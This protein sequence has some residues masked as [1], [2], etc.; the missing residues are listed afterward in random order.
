MT[1]RPKKP[2]GPG[3][4]ANWDRSQ[5]VR[6]EENAGRREWVLIDAAGPGAIVHVWGTWHG[7]KGGPFSNGTLRIYLDGAAEPIIAGPTTDIICG[8]ALIGPPFS[9]SVS[10]E[11][12]YERRGH[13]LY[14]PIPYAKHCKITYE[15]DKLTDIGGKE[16]DALYYQINYRTY[17]AGHPGRVLH[18]APS[19]TLL[20]PLVAQVGKRLVEPAVEAEIG[21]EVRCE[22]PLEPGEANEPG[23]HRPR[24]SVRLWK[25]KL[26]ADDLP[27]ALRSRLSSRST[28]DG[29]QTVWCPV[30]DFFGTGYRIS[31]FRTL[32]HAGRRRRHDAGL[33]WVMPFEKSCRAQHAQPWQQ[34]VDVEFRG[35][36]RPSDWTWD[37]RSLHFHATWRQYTKVDTGPDKDQTGQ[38]AFDVNYVEVEGQGKYVGDTLTLFNGA[39]AWWG[40]GDEKIYVDGEKY[41]SH[42]GTGTEDYY[43]YAWCR[44]EYF[45]AP[46]HAQ[47][48][49]D[50][51]LAG[52][53]SV[54]SRY[55]GS[56]C[57]PLR[58]L[59]QVRHGAL[60][61]AQQRA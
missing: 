5:F 12:P 60:A 20:K 55:R 33:C 10:P 56:R 52:G 51:N 11:T 18:A 40:E 47:P 46:F 34:P 54:N 61:L 22:R 57:H 45:T 21:R 25:M 49:G 3:W 32:V 16:G 36:D 48:C 8:Q 42:I 17:A 26:T 14:L 19:S 59:D 37:D 38:G 39:A 30:G 35:R 29:E 2:G 1:A 58:Q 24:G 13:N 15:S 4:F 31:P 6:S 44:P 53:F 28:F 27:Q 9:E 43:G 50:G 41:P 7:P 23:V